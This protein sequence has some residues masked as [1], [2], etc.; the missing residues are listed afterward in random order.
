MT[1]KPAT[2]RALR[3]IVGLTSTAYFMVVLDAV[4]VITALPRMQRDLHVGVSSLQWTVNAYGIAFA[5]GIITAAALGDRFGRR[6]I[7]NS[8]LALFTLASAACALAPNVSELI[9]ARTVQGLG[10]AAV[11]PLSLTILTTAFPPEKRGMIVGVYGGLAGLAVALGPIVGGAITEGIS[12]HWIFWINVPIGLAAV[13]LGLRTLPESHGAP[14]R[15]DLAGVSLVTAGV[16]AFVWALTR[17]NDVGWASAEI[18]GSL[19]VGCLLL[20]GF[21]WWERRAT[22]PMVPLR[23]FAS[24]EFAMGNLTTYFL[25]GATFAAAFF[26][27]QE[28]QLAR[29]YSPLGTG[30]RLLPFF[31]TP[32][33]VSPLAGA[34]SDRIGRRPIMVAGLALQALGYVWVASR[35]SLATSWIELDVALLVAGIG[36]SMALPT[37]PTTVLDAV[38]PEE[39]GKA[40]GIN[41][42]AQRFGTVFALAIGSAVFAAHG[43]LGSPAAVTAGFRPALWTC[44]CFAVLAALSGI[45]ITSSRRE[46]SRKAEPADLPIPA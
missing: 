3:G 11:L 15:L 32:M 28:F 35:G 41:Y 10:A 4:V 43:H 42:M 20:A 39:M 21:L 6:L 24:R 9:A 29:G 40:S 17:A 7:F 31:A 44:A 14:E 37:V 23:L 30:L 19:A 16:V 25:H 22:A 18:V 27:T 2:S 8:G 12:W 38:A 5:A 36:I 33:I 34:L 13:L 45:A 1:G 26:V 46:R